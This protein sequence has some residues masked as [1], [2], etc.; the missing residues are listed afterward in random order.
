MISNVN[1]II[2]SLLNNS[3]KEEII[4]VVGTVFERVLELK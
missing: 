1:Q 4:I 2:E 3:R